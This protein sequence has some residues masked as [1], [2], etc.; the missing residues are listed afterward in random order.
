ML[1][2]PLEKF[3]AKRVLI[4]AI[5][6]YMISFAFIPHKLAILAGLITGTFFGILRFSTMA[7]TF[8]DIII[9]SKTGA[10]TISVIKYVIN[11]ILTIILIC[12][13]LIYSAWFFA[14]MITGILLVPFVIIING[15]TEGLGI[16]H[17]NFE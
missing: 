12:F 7:R 2:S 8:S 9:N 10:A 1:G 16:T 13:S 3:I 15:I 5:I 6:V 14:G 4:L 11:F 17:N